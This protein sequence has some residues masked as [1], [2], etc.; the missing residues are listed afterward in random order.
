MCKSRIEEYRRLNKKTK[1]ME[2]A[3]QRYLYN[4]TKENIDLWF[5]ELRGDDI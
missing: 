1:L 3:Y 5:K 2:L 4:K